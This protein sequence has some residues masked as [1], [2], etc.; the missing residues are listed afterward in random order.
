MFPEVQK[1]HMPVKNT[2]KKLMKNPRI[3]LKKNTGLAG[4]E[5]LKKKIEI[6]IIGNPLVKKKKSILPVSLD[7]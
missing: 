6:K 3:I 4:P 7:R 1:D 2:I 5:M